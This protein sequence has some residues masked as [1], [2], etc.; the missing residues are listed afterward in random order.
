VSRREEC[1]IRSQGKSE[2]AGHFLM[3]THSAVF[4]QAQEVRNKACCVPGRSQGFCLGRLQ[5]T[6]LCLLPTSYQHM[7]IAV[8]PKVP[9][10][11]WEAHTYLCHA[12]QLDLLRLVV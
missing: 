2:R 8:L 7:L 1:V 3:L 6:W 4:R 9:C 5:G 11:S 12:Q 10:Y